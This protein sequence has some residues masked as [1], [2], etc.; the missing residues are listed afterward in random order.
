MTVMVLRPEI[1]GR[2]AEEIVALYQQR[3]MAMSPVLEQMRDVRDTYNG[4]LVVP[5]PELDRDERAAVANLLKTGIDQLAGRVAS[6]VPTLFC[7][8]RDPRKKTEVDA[9]RDRRRA[10]LGWWEMNNLKVVNYR[11]ARHMLGYG[12]SPVVIRPDRKRGIPQWHIRD[13]LG[14]FPAPRDNPDDMTP[15]DNV[16]AY[17]RTYGWL[18]DN[19][20]DQFNA[21]RRFDSCR[22]DDALEVLE[23]QDDE[24]NV[25]L[26]LAD[27]D[28]SPLVVKGPRGRDSNRLSSS[29]GKAL[30]SEY[31]VELERNRNKAEICTVVFPGRVTLDRIAGQFDGMLGMYAMSAKLMALEV[32]AV[33]KGVFP[34]TYLISRQG[35][36]AKFLSGPHD[37]RSGLVNIV[38]GGDIKEVAANPG[39]QTNPTIDRLER[40]QRLTGG[41]P[42]EFGGESTSNIRTGRRGDAVLSAAVE[43][44]VQEQ[45]ELMAHSAQEE[46]K[47]AIAVQTGYFGSRK[48]S[49]YVNWKGAK[50]HVEYVANKLF[51][52]DE[53]IVT[54][55]HAGT[56]LNGLTIMTG[57]LVG[58]GILSKQTA[59]ELLPLIEDPEQEHDRTIRESLESALVSG[60]QQKVASGEV[61]PADAAWVMQQVVTGKLEFPE[62]IIKA[63]ERVSE[64]QAQ[65]VEA[66]TPQAQGGLATGTP[67]EA[68]A[69]QP[70][71]P[72]GPASQANLANTLGALR[73]GQMTI[74]S[75]RPAVVA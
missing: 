61:A 2:E 38:A 50:G 57:Q 10:I 22:R 74:A 9:A 8:P 24:V 15:R 27:R 41:I 17:M 4:E 46:N 48:N 45:Q 42:A 47:R 28:V 5:L 49:Y 23:Y 67:A 54:Y 72:A 37:G 11:R 43:F 75:E 32:I 3:R 13:P 71:I 26:A 56:D 66:N 55:S 44:P 62:A 30:G 70:T 1:G 18:Q 14:S 33:E 60:W 25:M 68:Q 51:T 65:L 64:R 21:L 6:T 59:A 53:N 20:P 39:F 35:E 34:D 29:S 52:T 7:P 63:D 31:V 58:M 19:Y 16:F 73:R 12:G 36:Q 40:A 69:V